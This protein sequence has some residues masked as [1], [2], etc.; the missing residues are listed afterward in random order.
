[1]YT[2]FPNKREKKTHTDCDLSD[3]QLCHSCHTRN[4]KIRTKSVCVQKRWRENV[5]QTQRLTDN[6]PR[7]IFD[8]IYMQTHAR[9]YN[10]RRKEKHIKQKQSFFLLL[11]NG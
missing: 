4:K 9:T 6:S 1:M 10:R 3:G 11:Q 7:K 8:K 2:T 5:R